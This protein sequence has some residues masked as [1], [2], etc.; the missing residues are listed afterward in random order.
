MHN[1]EELSRILKRRKNRAFGSSGASGAVSD[2]RTA[3]TVEHSVGMRDSNG[4]TALKKVSYS[5]SPTSWHGVRPCSKAPI[6]ML[7]DETANAKFALTGTTVLSRTN[8]LVKEICV[9][10][11]NFNLGNNK[12]EMYGVPQITPLGTTQEKE[13]HRFQYAVHDLRDRFRVGDPVQSN[14]QNRKEAHLS[15]IPLESRIAVWSYLP[16]RRSQLLES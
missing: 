14:S 8:S 16:M 12:I 7:F 13:P 6:K 10:E 9:D 1:S 11:T 5:C 4:L 15:L 3:A 2:G